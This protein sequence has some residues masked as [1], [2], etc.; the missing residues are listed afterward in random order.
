MLG[1]RGLKSRSQGKRKHKDVMGVIPQAKRY[2]T[3]YLVHGDESLPEG[4]PW[5]PH[6]VP[7]LFATNGRPYLRQLRT[8]SGIWFLDAR[9]PQNHPEP[10]E[11][12][13]T[14]E[15][16][17]DL[18]RQD[19]DATYARLKVEP[20]PYID[21]DYQR[22]AILAVEK[23]LEDGRRELLVAMATGTGKT[24]TCIGLCYR[25][26]KAKRFRRVLFLVDRTALGEQTADALKDLRLENLQPFTEIF[27]VKELREA[28]RA[29]RAAA[30][31][32]CGVRLGEARAIKGDI[33]RARAEFLAE[34]QYQADLRRIE[35]ANRQ[36]RKEAPRVTR[37]E[38]QAE[39]DDE[40]RG[41]IPP[42]LLPL[43]ERVKRG[44]KA[45]PRM[46]RT[47][48]FLQ[49]AEEH[50]DEVLATVDDKTDA[51][52]RELEEQERQVRRNLRL[53]PPRPRYTPEQFAEVPF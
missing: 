14:P 22:S 49:Y 45:S 4:S 24:R 7:F 44:I 11:G 18:L 48:A 6:K 35:R 40:V 23:G 10:L 12:W 36:R 16:L 33:Q 52:I 27:D 53:G 37:I 50:P 5:G 28:M 43:F 26:L 13:Y 21:R 9:R 20:M 47:E 1:C 31:Q 29:E 38:R 39:S 19:V 15:G 42:E 51:L 8:K 2:S 34:K 46:S 41:N 25:L 32:S 3:G 30:R 17:Q